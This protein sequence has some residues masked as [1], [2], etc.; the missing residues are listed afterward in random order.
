MMEGVVQVFRLPFCGTVR[1]G[2]WS[3]KW[4]CA[5]CRADSEKE[6]RQA[7]PPIAACMGAAASVAQ[8]SS[9]AARYGWLTPPAALRDWDWTGRLRRGG[10]YV[11]VLVPEYSLPGNGGATP[12]SAEHQLGGIRDSDTSS[13]PSWGS[14]F[15]GHAPGSSGFVHSP[16]IP[17]FHHS[18]IPSFQYSTIPSFRPRRQASRLRYGFHIPPFHHSSIPLQGGRRGRLRY[19]SLPRSGNGLRSWE[20]A[21]GFVGR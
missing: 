9:P 8:A 19:V 6:S 13:L 20:S 1:E 14:A 12:G 7:R 4:G 16:A 21:K 11:R 18:S 17:P 10:S 2:I 5:C 15:P 3:E